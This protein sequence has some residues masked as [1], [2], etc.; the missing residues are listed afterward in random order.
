[1]SIFSPDATTTAIP[2]SS[3]GQ[4]VRERRRRKNLTQK[5]LGS[6]IG[7]A[8]IT[9]RQVESDRYVLT[10]FVVERLVEALADER[11][12]RDAILRF[13][14]RDAPIAPDIPLVGAGYRSG[15]PFLGRDEE[16]AT[17]TA[18]LRN[19][20]CRCISIV[21]V[22]GVG[23][24][25][26]AARAFAAC[27]GELFPEAFFVS[28][29]QATTS[30]Q[31]ARVIAT[32][33][34]ITLT[35]F[36]A[37][38]DQLVQALASSK[39]LLVLDNFEQLLPES[40][41][42]LTA[43]LA[44]TRNITL[45]ITS[46]ERLQISNEWSLRLQG[47][48]MAKGTSLTDAVSLFI[49]AAR[50]RDLQFVPSDREAILAICRQLQG[51][52]LAIEMAASWTD[53][54]TC[55][56]ILNSLATKMLNL[57][58]RYRDVEARHQSLYAVFETTWE[59]LSVP[60]RVTL[61]RLAVFRGGFTP[62]ASLAV[63][64]TKLGVLAFLQD[65]MLLDRQGE[66]L[67]LHEMIRQLALQK[68]MADE[69]AE[70][71]ARLAHAEYYIGSLKHS[72]QR[73]KFIYAY[74][75]VPRMRREIENLHLA[76]STMLD[77]RR[78][79]WFELCWE[80]LWLFYNVTSSFQEGEALF[81]RAAQVF[82]SANGNPAEK[83]LGDFCRVLVASFL[84]RQ[85]HI[86]EAHNFIS[87]PNMDDIHR[88]EDLRDAYHVHVIDSYVFH[89]LGDG[90]SALA[91]IERGVT[92]LAQMEPTDPYLIIVTSFQLGRVQHLLGNAEAAYAK[93]SQTLRLW[94]LDAL[95]WGA[96]IVQTEMGLAAETLGKTEDA[97]THYTAVLAAASEWEDLWNYH[98]TQIS[99]GRVKLTLGRVPEAIATFHVTLQGLLG[100][101]Q[102][103]LEIDCFAEVALVLNMAG[104]G[105]LCV[106]LLEYC[107]V[108]PECYQ[109]A[110]DTAARYLQSIRAAQPTA[111]AANQIALPPDKHHI[112]IM[113]I[114]ELIQFQRYIS[115]PSDPG[116]PHV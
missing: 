53:I 81:R 68:L 93:L 38:Q 88:S 74:E 82:D 69:N 32:A 105:G 104:K 115:V 80:S 5:A 59:R 77:E 18:L 102:L 27:A 21:G 109:S 76:W 89:A 24:T 70:L 47:L 37:P 61:M 28:L 108:H 84:L 26:L 2:I 4:W 7:Y 55:A 50:R 73:I 79:D 56:E 54:Y 36:A 46:R 29:T 23:K 9:V 10:R 13:V 111:S 16:M 6:L 112:G 44:N 87:H 96:G 15:T 39:L 33:L 101:P 60:E 107:A 11:D 45:L 19:P 1:M 30:D 20:E 100:N 64:A 95:G 72:A 40:T 35:P 31:M 34:G 12:D 86:P 63:A 49:C 67:F 22:G 43:M 97:L 83:R 48:G 110:R 90:A 92:A 71:E 52:P 113:L 42:F 75:E 3:F 57:T 58:S 98:R 41:Q 103:G 51:I 62:E 65:K 66:R 17:I 14:L 99:I 78:L 94:R 25:R 85:G 106:T 8:E 116:S 91:S 114:D